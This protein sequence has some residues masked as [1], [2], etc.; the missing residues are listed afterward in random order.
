MPRQ[1]RKRFRLTKYLFLILPLLLSCA[2][3]TLEIDIERIDVGDLIAKVV[4]SE[5]GVNS[6][7]GLASVKIESPYDKVS[8]KQV[9]IAEEPNLLRL[10]AIAPFG[11]TVGMV[12]SNGE[13][14]YVISARERSEF[15]NPEQFDLSYFY[16]DLPVKISLESL[17]NLLLGRLPEEPD[18]VNSR[19]LVGVDEGRVVLSLFKGNIKESVLWIDP[20]NY[21]ISKAIITLEN[22]SVATCEF[23]DFMYVGNGAQIPRR[24]EL[25]V[26]E[27]LISLKYDSDLDVNT[28]IDRDLFKPQ[29]AFA[30]LKKYPPIHI[31]K[32]RTVLDSW[33]LLISNNKNKYT[34]K[35]APR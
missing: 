20:Q 9:T 7:K 12:I 13:K 4:D 11:R 30:G 18:F 24:I 33:G 6:V 31:I 1:E 16:P 23:Q 3:K 8:Y 28:E 15:D 17:V 26:D 27:Y 29:P 5:D 35:L 2:K 10:E 19:V 14:V 22:G 21:R 32:D 25:R 34:N